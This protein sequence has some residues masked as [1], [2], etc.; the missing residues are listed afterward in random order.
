[1]STNGFQGKVLPAGTPLSIQ[2]EHMSKDL[3]ENPLHFKKYHGLIQK[4]LEPLLETKGEVVIEDNGKCH[5]ELGETLIADFGVI[6]LTT[7]RTYTGECVQHSLE[8]L[9]ISA[10]SEPKVVQVEFSELN[11]HR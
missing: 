8:L 7:I 3:K 4:L 11:S 1:M 9:I 2:Y 5:I 6:L 10:D